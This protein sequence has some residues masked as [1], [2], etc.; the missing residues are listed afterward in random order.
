M[1]VCKQAFHFHIYVVPN[2]MVCLSLS[3]SVCLSLSLSLT[4]SLTSSGEFLCVDDFGGEFQ[5]C[6]LLHAPSHHGKGTFS[7][8]LL[9]LVVVREL[10]SRVLSHF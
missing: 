4:H 3:V 1:Y 8:F 2:P 7:E 5:A 9:E 10:C 6:G